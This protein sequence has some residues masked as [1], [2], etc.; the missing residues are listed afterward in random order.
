[1]YLTSIGMWALRLLDG[2]SRS[3]GLLAGFGIHM[4]ALHLQ[5]VIP[6]ETQDGVVWDFGYLS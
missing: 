2:I 3:V 6:M 1:M 4:S 5:V